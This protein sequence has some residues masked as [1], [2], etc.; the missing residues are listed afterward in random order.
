MLYI[1]RCTP[2]T[3]QVYPTVK[4]AQKNKAL[5]MNYSCLK[6]K[7]PVRQIDCFNFTGNRKVKNCVACLQASWLW[8]FREERLDS[9]LLHSSQL[10]SSICCLTDVTGQI[11]HNS[12]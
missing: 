11:L 2:K 1:F 6:A 8:P 12:P 10:A 4:W 5:V 3:S 9:F 7:L